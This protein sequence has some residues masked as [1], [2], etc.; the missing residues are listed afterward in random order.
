MYNYDKRIFK[1]PKIHGTMVSKSKKMLE[2]NASLW[3]A[4]RSYSY[5]K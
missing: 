5:R 3:L 4:N 2:T 1:K